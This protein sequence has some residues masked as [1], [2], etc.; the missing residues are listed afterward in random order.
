MSFSR[1]RA[2]NQL[3]FLNTGQIIGIQDLSINNNFGNYPIRYIGIGSSPFPQSVNQPQYAD[4]DIN[5]DLI[6]QDY[7]I[8]LTGKNCFNMFILK[9]QQDII[10]NYCLI[11]GYLNSYSMKYTI[12]QIP[13]ITTSIRFYNGAGNTNT[14]KLDSNSFNQLAGI[15]GN[16]YTTSGTLVGLSNLVNLTLNEYNTNRVLDL[17]LKL[18]VNRIPIYNIGSR[19]PQRVDIIYPIDVTVDL[20]FEADINYDDIQL[21]DFPFNEQKQN[22]TIS[23]YGNSDDQFIN[24]YQFNNL[25]LINQKNSQRVD[26]NLNITR[27]YVGQIYDYIDIGSGYMI[28]GWDWG[29]VSS[30]INFFLDFGSVT[31]VIGGYY[32]FGSVTEFPH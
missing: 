20:T 15:T 27:E 1:I 31:G 21:T 24:T 17:T 25:T 13:Q 7:F 30:G 11:S 5:S 6:N 4:V 32:D 16:L 8:N 29:Y 2:E 14:G 23:I 18:D 19:F 3:V 22:V 26:G 12:N 10:D 28:S 9:N